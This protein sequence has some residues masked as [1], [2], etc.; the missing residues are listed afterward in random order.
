MSHLEYNHSTLWYFLMCIVSLTSYYNFAS[1]L[2]TLAL[3][4]LCV[5]MNRVMTEVRA[6]S[7]AVASAVAVPR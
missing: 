5:T 7:L 2:K 6:Q 4:G 3:Q 1:H